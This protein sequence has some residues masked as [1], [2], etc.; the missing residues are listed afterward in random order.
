MLAHLRKYHD[1]SI[2][3]IYNDILGFIANWKIHESGY[4]AFYKGLTCQKRGDSTEDT[5]EKQKWYDKAVAHYTEV[6]ALNPQNIAAYNNRGNAYSGKGDF[7][8]A[9]QNYAEAIALNRE[10]GTSY[11]TSAT[12][13]AY[14]S[15]CVEPRE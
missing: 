11:S 6:I 8:T 14:G 7:D 3:T 15:D 13:V 9:V 4:T 1:I 10:Y 2:R 5:L 12:A